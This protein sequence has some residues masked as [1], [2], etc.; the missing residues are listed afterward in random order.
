MVEAEVDKKNI[1][2]GTEGTTF[3]I[4]LDIV[5]LFL[6]MSHIFCSLCTHVV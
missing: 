1:K 6:E 5:W 2:D 4:G 3:D